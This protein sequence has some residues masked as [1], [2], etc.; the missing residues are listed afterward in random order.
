MDEHTSIHRRILKEL[1]KLI[2]K[3]ESDRKKDEES[4]QI[5]MD[6]FKK[7]GSLKTGKNKKQ[8]LSNTT[9]ALRVRD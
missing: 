1:R 3:E 7:E 6:M 5:I 2:Q 8:L 9:T 4:R